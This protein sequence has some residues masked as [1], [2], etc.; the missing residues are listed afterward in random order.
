MKA[1]LVALSQDFPMWEECLI[2]NASLADVIFI[3][4]DKDYYLGN[5][6]KLAKIVEGKLWGI[7]PTKDKTMNKFNWREELLTQVHHNAQAKGIEWIL[8]PDEDEKL[9]LDFD[10][11]TKEK[12][13]FMFEYKMISDGTHTPY[14]YP[15]KPHAKIFTYSP[16]LTYDPYFHFARVGAD[17]QPVKEIPTG[18]FI[19]HYCFYKKEWMDSKEASI[20][21]R[22][23]DYFKSNPKTY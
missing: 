6:E 15:S 8:F 11:N 7:F 9:P 1:L 16:Y 20:I 3:R 12:G 22:Y 18:K 14:V 21:A 19:E 23:P 2:H 4:L 10:F 5:R 17:K 13:Q